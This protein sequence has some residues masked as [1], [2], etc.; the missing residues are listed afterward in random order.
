VRWDSMD[1]RTNKS[2][3]GF[4]T[5]ALHPPTLK[6]SCSSSRGKKYNYYISAAFYS[7]SRLDC[8]T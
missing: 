6:P 4:K 1:I 8:L 5:R 7:K 2:N 3:D